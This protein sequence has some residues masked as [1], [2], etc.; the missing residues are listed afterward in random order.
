MSILSILYFGVA[1]CDPK[2]M[3]AATTKTRYNCYHQYVT[4]SSS[5]CLDLY[6][7]LKW[8]P[9][10]NDLLRAKIMSLLIYKIL[11]YEEVPRLE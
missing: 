11:N 2:K 10:P 6:F 8:C 9:R 5:G 3:M 7:A 1:D 4:S